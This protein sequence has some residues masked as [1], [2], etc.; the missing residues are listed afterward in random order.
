MGLKKNMLRVWLRENPI[1]TELLPIA[2][3]LYFTLGLNGLFW[4]RIVVQDLAHA[5]AD[6][7][8][9]LFALGFVDFPSLATR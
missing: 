1:G 9:Y 7:V 6:R 3:A 8:I 5:S 4:D 2:L